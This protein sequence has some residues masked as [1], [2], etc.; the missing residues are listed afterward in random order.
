[1]ALLAELVLQILPPISQQF[2]SSPDSTLVQLVGR[3]VREM[4]EEEDM[5]EIVINTETAKFLQ[6]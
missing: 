1:M 6:V 4:V 3:K 5:L 2:L